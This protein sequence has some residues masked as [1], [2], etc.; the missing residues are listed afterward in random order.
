MIDPANA[1]R[2]ERTAI[3]QGE[4][5]R[6]LTGHLVHLGAWHAAL[7]AAAFLVLWILFRRD[8]RLRQWL[9]I[10]IVSIVAIDAGLWLLDP[11][12][13]WYVGASGALHGIAAAGA[14]SRIRQMRREGWVLAALLVVKLSYE[15]AR[16]AMPFTES[17]PVVV[18]AHLYGA[19]GGTFAALLTWC[20]CRT[21]AR[22]RKA[23][24]PD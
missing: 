13:E 3:A 9:L 6:L 23:S 11:R 5:W 22:E 24:R 1:L 7:N 15:Q 19:I 14:V 10:V 16:G 4:W 17:M 18:D 20:F 2:Y 12:I 21:R 8:Y